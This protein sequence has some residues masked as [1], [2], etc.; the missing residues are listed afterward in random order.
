[1]DTIIKASDAAELLSLVPA[2]AGFTPVRSLVV[3]PFHGTR[4]PGVLRMDLPPGDDTPCDYVDDVLELL[5]QVRGCDAIAVV[6]YSDEAATHTRDGLVLPHSLLIDHL[7]GSAHEEGFHIVEGLCVLPSGWSDYLEPEP[8][9]H[10]LDGIPSAPELPGVD[11][12]T[13]QHTGTE[14]PPA[15]LAARQR[16]GMALRDLDAVLERVRCGGSQ[17]GSDENP[18]AIGAAV[19][20][21]D[22]PSFAEMLL[23]GEEDP[24]PFACAALLWCLHRPALRDAVLVQWASDHA[25]G[26]RAF[27]A[28]LGHARNGDR[29]PS[30]IGDVFLGRAGDPDPARL[31]RALEVVRYS[32]ACAPRDLKPGALA[33]A[34]WLSW[35]LGRSTHADAYLRMSQRI[36]PGH[37][38][39]ALLLRVLESA[40][41]PM[42]LMERGERLARRAG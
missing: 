18:Q 19:M 27:D 42:W 2:L 37:G 29:T 9:L 25:T 1:M 32:V 4:A 12:V 26:M 8:V 22:I 15:D 6:V 16:V 31:R 30:E 24:P 34:A 39:T 10:P 17:L 36:E 20:L 41:L 7:L 28:Q 14:L 5:A 35:A 13:D 33:S 3:L 21:D 38:L 40:L 23:E 11:V